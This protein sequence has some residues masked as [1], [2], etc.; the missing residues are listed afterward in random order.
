MSFDRISEEIAH[1]I[2]SFHLMVEGNRLRLEYEAFSFERSEDSHT[3]PAPPDLKVGAGFS[4]KGF[5]PGLAYLRPPADTAGLAHPPGQSI[6]ST[7]AVED[8][9]P[10]APMP[11]ETTLTP[12]AGAQF[13]GVYVPLP[14]SI[15]LNLR[16]TAQLSDNDLLLVTGGTE[17]I[18]PTALLAGF[19]EL[20]AL[21][22]TLQAPALETDAALP[23]L[24]PVAELA[25]ALSDFSPEGGDAEGGYAVTAEPAGEALERLVPVGVRAAADVV[26]DVA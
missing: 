11:E 21:A 22:R 14:N 17:F 24:D 13:W 18:D 3:L 5:D 16:Q 8:F 10:L 15:L 20:I 9:R 6:S 4:L 1:F 12:P 25:S 23:R 26:G 19:D 7:V 2:G